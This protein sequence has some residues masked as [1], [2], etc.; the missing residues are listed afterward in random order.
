[1]HNDILNTDNIGAVLS[2]IIFI[3]LDS[4][5]ECI[6]VLQITGRTLDARTPPPIYP[7]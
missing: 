2:G 4:L 3:M 5:D 6:D 7:T 1:M